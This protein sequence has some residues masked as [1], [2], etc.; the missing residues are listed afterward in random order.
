MKDDYRKHK[1]L[2]MHIFLLY[3]KTKTMNIL[4][5]LFGKKRVKYD[6]RQIFLNFN[7]SLHT[8]KEKKSLISSIITRIKELVPVKDI[9]LFWEDDDTNRYLLEILDG[10]KQKL[11]LLPHDGLIN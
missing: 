11:Y 3:L 9:Y 10:S 1:L 4:R 2:L 6:Y 8:I 7:R 5:Q